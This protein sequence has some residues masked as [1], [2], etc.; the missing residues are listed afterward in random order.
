[1]KD[2]KYL[3]T[4]C[5]SP[6]YAAPEVVSAKFKNSF[7]I[8]LFYLRKY[9]GTEVDT[10]SCGVILYALLAGFLPFDEDVIPKL[11]KKIRG[12]FLF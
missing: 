1:M 10:W 9:C 7:L 11:F 12:F 2:G 4:S 8:V 3:N 6:N 5:G